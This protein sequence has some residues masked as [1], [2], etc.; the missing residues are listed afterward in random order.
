L[1]RRY[2]ICQRRSQNNQVTDGETVT[3]R[4][5]VQL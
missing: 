1:L 3:E 2:I 5:R 4:D